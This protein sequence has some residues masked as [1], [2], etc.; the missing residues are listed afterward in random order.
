LLKHSLL[1]LQNLAKRAFRGV[2]LEVQYLKRAVTE[3]AILRNVLRI[4]DPVAILDVGANVGQYARSARQLGFRG[5][6]VSFEPLSKAHVAL[7]AAAGQDRDWIVAPRAA[8]G[9]ARG[10]ATLNISQNTVSSSLLPLQSRG[11]VAAP[12]SRYVGSEEVSV[13]RLDELAPPLVPTTGSLMLKIDTQ[14][15]EMEVLGGASGL[16]ERIAALQVELSLVQ[17]YA[18]SPSLGGMLCYIDELGFEPFGLAA[19][20]KDPD[21]GR[22]LQAE[23]FFVRSPAA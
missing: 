8:L 9:R 4:T 1:L 14:G 21:S 23:G 13:H 12:A 10:S 5:R 20:F 6:I 2:G 16:L 7:Q 15:Y 18:G 17:L 22:Q 19:G 11:V 3:E